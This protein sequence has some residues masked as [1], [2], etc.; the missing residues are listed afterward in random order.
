MVTVNRQLYVTAC[1]F[2]AFILLLG[3]AGCGSPAE[4]E[5]VVEAE[6]VEEIVDEAD[7]DDAE[8]AIDET[9]EIDVEASPV[10]IDEWRNPTDLVALVNMFEELQWSWTTIEN[11]VE[12]DTFLVSYSYAGS[13]TIDG[14]DTSVA[15]IT[16]EGQE[17]RAWLDEDGTARQAEIDGELIPGEFADTMMEGMLM[18]LFW[19]FRMVDSYDVQNM[20]QESGPGIEW[21]TISTDQEQFNG[22][23]AEVTRVQFE[24]SPPAI[25]E[26]EEISII[27]AVADFGGDFQM[28]IE[29]IV[30]ETDIDDF[31]FSMTVDKIAPR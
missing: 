30:E 23:G 12:T 1:L 25:P 28:L 4:E 9:E 29:W 31:S 2:T 22:L 10:D 5:E 17:T 15:V 8:D 14:A 16:F 6:D 26:G 19:P 3:A 13:E 7:L 20:L 21:N 24:L 27:L 11:G 18:S